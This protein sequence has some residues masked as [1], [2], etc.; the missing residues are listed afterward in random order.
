MNDTIH[1]SSETH[2]S[3]AAGGRSAGAGRLVVVSN[4]VANP[5]QLQT[6]G[7]ATALRAA[8]AARGGIWFGWSG[9][10]VADGCEPQ[11][12]REERGNVVFATMDLHESDLEGYYAN[13]ANRVL[14]P[15]FHYRL[16]LVEYHRD[17]Y[18]S[19]Q[20]VNR[21]FAER[22]ALLIRP[23]DIIWIHDYHLIPLAG[24]LRRLG[25]NNRIGFFLHTP[26]APE[27][28][29]RTLPPHRELIGALQYYDLVGLQSGDDLRAL[30]E[31]F[32]LS[33]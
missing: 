5:D 24:H 12:H 19:Y 6:G 25:F 2:S 16:D 11:L 7:L 14:W 15:L 1:E 28:L 8:L 31:Y 29:L 3:N 32:R 9:Q 17:T 26:L 22:L 4:R 20:A 27:E 18:A 30:R 10:T 23:D 13:F 21:C 33:L